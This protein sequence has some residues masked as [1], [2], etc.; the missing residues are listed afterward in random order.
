MN[1]NDL[2][3]VRILIVEDDY[4]LATDAETTLRSA[5]ATILGPCGDEGSALAIVAGETLDCAIL[6]VNLG[7]GP[8]FHLATTMRTRGIP[9][10]FVTGYDHDVIPDEFGD[11]A[12]LQKPYLEHHLHNAIARLLRVAQ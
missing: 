9:F 6:D 3:G 12:R 10:V 5:G 4:Y 8:S 7:P 2:S 11:V 1:A